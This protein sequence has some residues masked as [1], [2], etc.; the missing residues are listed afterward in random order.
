MESVGEWA[1][2]EKTIMGAA[3]Q[4]NL[5]NDM[6]TDPSGAKDIEVLEASNRFANVPVSRI[7]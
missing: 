5:F 2:G 1:Y 3:K 7:F 6:K 4:S